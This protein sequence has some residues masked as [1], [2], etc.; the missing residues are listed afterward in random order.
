MAE[1]DV[2]IKARELLADGQWHAREDLIAQLMV[3]V[4]PGVAYRKIEDRRRRRQ[5]KWSGRSTDRTKPRDASD[6]IHSGQRKI[7]VDTLTAAK[8]RGKVEVRDGPHDLMIR[9]APQAPPPPPWTKLTE[10]HLQ[11][12][13]DYAAGMTMAES[14]DRFGIAPSTLS[15]LRRFVA[16]KLGVPYEREAVIARAKELGLLD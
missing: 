8:L 6:V 9:L 7:A 3:L 15:G 14:A 13:R 11:V 1:T 12:L 5:Q 10:R 4:P 16:K 2:W